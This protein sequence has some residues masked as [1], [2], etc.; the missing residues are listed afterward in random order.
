MYAR[1]DDRLRKG[2]SEGL[3]LKVTVTLLVRSISDAVA[4][5][6]TATGADVNSF[7]ESGR[8]LHKNGV[9]ELWREWDG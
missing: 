7:I 8:S 9:T 3:V 2:L 5:A 6:M 1:N 4:D